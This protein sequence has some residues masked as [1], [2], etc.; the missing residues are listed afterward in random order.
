MDQQDIGQTGTPSATP[1]ATP[2]PTSGSRMDSASGASSGRSGMDSSDPL[3]ANAGDEMLDRIVQV[4]HEAIDRL[5]GTAAPHV[6]RIQEQ[7]GHV[8]ETFNLQA[9][10][11][12]ATG[13]EWAE[14]LRDTVREH[15]LAAVATAVALGMLLTRLT[16]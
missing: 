13:E 9:S 14:G 3:A 7:I 11:V 16:R 8:G 1:G 10:D 6:H 5:A 15:P 12:R 4:A 2:F